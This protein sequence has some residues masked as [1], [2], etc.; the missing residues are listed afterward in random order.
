MLGACRRRADVSNRV[1]QERALQGYAFGLG[2]KSS[3]LGRPMAEA[4]K[5]NYAAPN[6]IIRQN[7]R[8]SLLW[9]R[10]FAV[11]DGGQAFVPIALAYFLF[12][13]LERLL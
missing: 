12:R 1:R 11:A 5:D 9:Q 2:S 8:M 10:F 6:F 3:C 7:G 13:S 4:L